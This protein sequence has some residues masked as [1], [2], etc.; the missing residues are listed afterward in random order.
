MDKKILFITIFLLILFVFYRFVYLSYY[1]IK[2][3]GG[4]SASTAVVIADIAVVVIVSHAIIARAVICIVRYSAA[5]AACVVSYSL[6]L[7][8]YNFARNRM[9]IIFVFVSISGKFQLEDRCAV[10]M[11][12][13]FIFKYS[14]R[15][16]DVGLQQGYFLCF[17]QSNVRRRLV[18]LGISL[19]DMERQR[20]VC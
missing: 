2:D 7:G 14:V 17:L 5:A 13:L 4:K 16:A 6:M 15:C 12:E 1:D 19:S 18:I 20:C 3:S 11:V 9:D 10:V 8:F